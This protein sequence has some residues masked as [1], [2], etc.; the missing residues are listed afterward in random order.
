[1]WSIWFRYATV[2]D[3]VVFPYH[4]VVLA[5]LLTPSVGTP[6]YSMNSLFINQHVGAFWA[7]LVA[8][9]QTTGG[10]AGPGWA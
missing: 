10:G 4:T 3:S 8:L 1:M 9:E 6:Y 2:L 7:T 5:S